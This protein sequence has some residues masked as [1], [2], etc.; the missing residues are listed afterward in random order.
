MSMKNSNDTIG[1]G[2][3]DVPACSA[4][5]QPTAPPCVQSATKHWYTLHLVVFFFFLR[6]LFSFFLSS[7]SLTFCG[8]LMY[9]VFSWP[10]E[11]KQHKL[12]AFKQSCVASIKK[13]NMT[14]GRE[15]RCVEVS[16]LGC[17]WWTVQTFI[18]NGEVIF[19]I[20][21]SLHCYF[22]LWFNKLS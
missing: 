8:P 17:A 16:K 1:N 19:L 11:L 7:F 3:H 5:P 15:I 18:I 13:I 10:L 6:F 14:C 21:V 2:T 20:S 4:V 9:H 22:M 12:H